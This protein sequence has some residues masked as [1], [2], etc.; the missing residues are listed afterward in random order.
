MPREAFTKYL[1]GW[2]DDGE[3][4]L[5]VKAKVKELLH[6]VKTADGKFYHYS[7]PFPFLY[8]PKEGGRR[9][10]LATQFANSLLMQASRLKLKDNIGK[11][12]PDMVLFEQLFL[13]NELLPRIAIYPG[14]ASGDMYGFGASMAIDPS[15]RMLIMKD[16]DPGDRID[17]SAATKTFIEEVGGLG[18]VEVAEAPKVFAKNP[19]PSKKPSGK[20]KAY[21]TALD[22]KLWEIF[23]RTGKVHLAVD[24]F[25]GT[26][27][28]AMN[29]RAF[30]SQK[31]EPRRT[32][33]ARVRRAWLELN[34]R[35]TFQDLTREQKMKDFIKTRTD[36]SLPEKTNVVVLWS[37]FTG[38]T[39][40]A[41][42]EYDTS[43][44][45]LRQLVECAFA[46][47]AEYV[48]IAGDAPK[49]ATS[50]PEEK[51]KKAR[52]FMGELQ[53][54][55][56]GSQTGRFIKKRGP[57]GLHTVAKKLVDLT[58]F[59]NLDEWRTAN[60][61]MKPAKAKRIDQFKLFEV[62]ARNNRVKH[63]G[64]RS[65]NLESL[66]LLGY[67]V[68]YFEDG[69]V[70]KSWEDR[71]AISEDFWSGDLGK[72][73]GENVVEQVI[74]QQQKQEIEDA[75]DK[76]RM[77]P[78]HDTVGYRRIKISQVPTR[79]GKYLLAKGL[80]GQ[81]KWSYPSRGGNLDDG[82]DAFAGYVGAQQKNPELPL[83]LFASE[84]D[85]RTALPT[86]KP[87]VEGIAKG[88]TSSDLIEIANFLSF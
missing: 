77:V 56:H 22:T 24:L 36:G 39:G 28:V 21:L 33:R 19:N 71:W 67:N 44:T 6:G 5:D 37:R 15:L 83:P 14:Y 38:K 25:F 27:Y 84:D 29:Y 42:V 78:W 34:E 85:I 54:A 80:D 87:K 40:G 50:A 51:K 69:T 81:P 13:L 10:G 82:E 66:A 52:E 76:Q 41:H 60:G 35:G 17:R 70:D 65:G 79:S 63:L 47:G 55:I 57:N 23:L 72:N 61:V 32:A 74:P 11:A 73:V 9:Y 26:R 20:E 2:V 43:R 53:K 30:Q 86:Y 3:L 46:G 45:G 58:E 7:C 16:Q 64:A 4:D 49:A 62:L 88:F 59:W 75:M 1:A 48:F 12:I 8:D 68:R 18:R 31:G